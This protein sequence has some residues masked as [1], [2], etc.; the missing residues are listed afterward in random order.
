MDKGRAN[1][2]QGVKP[3]ASGGLQP[4]QQADGPGAEPAGLGDA[5]PDPV[6]AP[7]YDLR[8][9]RRCLA[10]T[11]TAAELAEIG[12]RFGCATSA[13]GAT[14]QPSADESARL[15]LRELEHKGQVHELVQWLHQNQPL[16]Q[17]PLPLQPA[18]ASLSSPPQAA[19]APVEPLP[20]VGPGPMP[21]PARAEPP[22][23]IVDPFL[24]AGSD[25]SH[26]AS[27]DERP[28]WQRREWRMA[29]IAAAAGVVLL[30]A[31]GAGFL[32]GRSGAGA[33][34][35]PAQAT[36]SAEP[37]HSAARGALALTAA[38]ELLRSVTDIAETCGLTDKSGPAKQVLTRAFQA[39]GPTR[40]PLSQ[41]PSRA[42]SPSD[43]SAPEPTAARPTASPAVA[44]ADRP[45]D[46]AP[47]GGSCLSHCSEEH[48]QCKASE[49]GPEPMQGS[50][51][52]AYQKCLSRCLSKA[53][54]CRLRC[55]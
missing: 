21:S 14:A 3:A 10:L 17:W 55:G 49:C 4:G 54:Q 27:E 24:A 28:L 31:V 40:T 32:F 19:A 30:T 2:G 52:D 41:M 16:M 34:A 45:A 46:P 51:Y 23:P 50:Q 43:T 15:L 47:G 37:A 38:A 20:Q 18:A 53:S 9:L 6:P 39:C 7:K 5:P 36:G 8:E 48:R 29:A 33:S 35:S 12:Q 26:P 42:S 11:V 13:A 1:E 22:K 25:A 44:P